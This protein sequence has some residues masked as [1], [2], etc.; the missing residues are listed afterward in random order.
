MNAAGKVTAGEI[1][2]EIHQVGGDMVMN[3]ELFDVFQK[4]NEK[5]LAYHIEIGSQERT[6]ASG[7]IDE[8]IEK[9]QKGLEK[10]LKVSIRR[11]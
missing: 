7:E 6:L 11:K 1:L 3:A 10:K 9:I 8:I 5:N 4:E 2:K